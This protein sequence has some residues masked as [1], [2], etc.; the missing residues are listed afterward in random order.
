MCCELMS[1]SSLAGHACYLMDSGRYMVCTNYMDCT[2]AET[3]I[4]ENFV[5]NLFFLAVFFVFTCAITSVP[6]KIKNPYLY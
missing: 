2:E 1:V 5:N 3:T 6:I 4:F